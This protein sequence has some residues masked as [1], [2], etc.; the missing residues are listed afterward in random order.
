MLQCIVGQPEV[1]LEPRSVE[2][3]VL[4][5]QCIV[6]QPEVSLEPRSVEGHVLMLQCIVGQPEFVQRAQCSQL[7]AQST[8]TCSGSLPPPVRSGPV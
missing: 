5:L 1:S 2:G 7:P 6:G 4:M 8:T 3:H